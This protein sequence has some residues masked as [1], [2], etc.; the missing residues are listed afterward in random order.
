[1]EKKTGNPAA[2]DPTVWTKLLP[3]LRSGSQRK[4][5]ASGIA[6]FLA[7]PALGYRWGTG[8]LEGIPLTPGWDQLRAD[9]SASTTISPFFSGARPPTPGVESPL[10]GPDGAGPAGKPGIPPNPE[11]WITRTD[12][13]LIPFSRLLR[14]LFRRTLLVGGRRKE[15]PNRS[16]RIPGVRRSAPPTRI[17]RP[18]RR[19]LP[20]KRPFANSPRT[21]QI[22]RRPSTRAN[23]A[24]AKPVM[25]TKAMVGRNPTSRPIWRRM[26]NSKRGIPTKRSVS[27]AK[28]DMKLFTPW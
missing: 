15:K 27:R 21:L 16:V 12:P 14:T 6:S 22:V 3:P 20:G 23:A 5:R 8:S 25:I 10:W 7:A 19:A 4:S 2:Q 18:S 1:M 11:K 24:P 26:N 17:A 9:S 13:V 28:R